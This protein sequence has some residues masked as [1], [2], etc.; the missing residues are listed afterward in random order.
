MQS[1]GRPTPYRHCVAHREVL[2]TAKWRPRA[3]QAEV[4]IIGFWV[5]WAGPVGRCRIQEMDDQPALGPG[6]GKNIVF[7]PSLWRSVA[8]GQ[9]LPLGLLEAPHNE[10]A[11]ADV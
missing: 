10:G 2:A 5:E 9:V 6:A 8:R 1:H 4:A 3:A 7:R 11:L